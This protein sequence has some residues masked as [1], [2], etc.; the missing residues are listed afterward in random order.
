M[1]DTPERVWHYF[2]D[3]EGHLWHDDEE[4]DDP[5][6]LNLFMKNMELLPG[7]KFRVF[8]QGEE[9]RITPEDVPYVVKD[10]AISPK[11]IGLTFPGDYR[12]VLD[13]STLFVG[14]G[15]VLYCKVRGGKFTA[16]FNRKSYLDLAKKVK[17]DSRKKTYYLTVDRHDYSIKGVT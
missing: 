8:C 5:Q 16:R 10:V 13:P 12:E 17:F 4:F 15:N 6:L 3:S 11:K 7:G 1:K 2:I 9:C 14:R